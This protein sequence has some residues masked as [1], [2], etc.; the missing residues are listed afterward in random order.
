MKWPDSSYCAFLCEPEHNYDENSDFADRSQAKKRNKKAVR[1]TLLAIKKFQRRKSG[2][3]SAG[4]SL[5]KDLSLH[6]TERKNLQKM[7]STVKMLGLFQHYDDKKSK[8]V[9]IH[10]KS[11]TGNTG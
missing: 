4:I 1:S 5:T 11:A 9:I 3:V 6:N 2:K 7:D 8:V 10:S